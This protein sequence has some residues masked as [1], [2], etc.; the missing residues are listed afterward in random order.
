MNDSHDDPRFS[1]LARK[2]APGGTLLRVW[3]LHGGVS[4]QVT[5]ME[6]QDPDG[7]IQTLT[8]RQHGAADRA[9]N[10]N[11][12]A[13]E[14]RLLTA[15]HT[16][17][18]P[19]PKPYAVDASGDIFE[20]PVIVV[21][22]IEG[23]SVFA[24]DNAPDLIPQ[25]AAQ[26]AVIHRV[27]V[28]SLDTS[29]LPRQDDILTA[30]VR[31]RPARLDD[32]LE[33]GRIRDALEAVW[34]LPLSNPSGL[35]HGD[36]WPGNILW[37]AGRLVGVL[38]WEDAALGDPLADLA[39]SRLEILWAFSLDAMRQFT[40]DYSASTAARPLDLTNLPYWDLCAALRPAGRLSD[41]A[42]DEAAE[43]R[44]R[45]RHH[46]FVAQAFEQLTSC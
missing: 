38:D 19:A 27:D 22:Y 1:W 31:Q 9:R 26:L 13:D 34:P 25:L 33:E 7:R 32:T 35:L 4:A 36:Y 40:H 29:F 12:A 15:L 3:P 46:L 39:N 41:W 11:I 28:T 2:I 21:E 30:N 6:L 16:A 14:F 5:A 44:M 17:G 37:R 43:R 18:V 20:T 24:L 10:P 8:V 42:T 23:E 45:E